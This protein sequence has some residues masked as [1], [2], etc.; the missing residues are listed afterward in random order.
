MKTEIILTPEVQAVVDAIKNTGKSW[1][2]IALPD[3]P[4]YP[5]FARKLVVTGFNTP[6][7]GDTEDRIYVYVRQHLILKESNTVHKKL[8]LPEWMIH[9]GN[10]EEIMGADGNLL[11]KTVIVKDDDDNVISETEE[12]LKVQS[13]QYVRFL[14]KSKSA[15]LTDVL[16]RFMTLYAQIFE[17][18]INEL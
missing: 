10:M 15:H 2:E 18:K 16:G 7:M 12:P 6:D 9:E 13:V 4:I 8:K 11:T 5:Q 1:H 17:T 3:H 14:I